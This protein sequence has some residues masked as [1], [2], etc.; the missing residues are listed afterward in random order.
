V[1]VTPHIGFNSYEAVERINRTTVEN[2]MGFAAGA[3]R[4]VVEAKAR[5]AM[6]RRIAM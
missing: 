3:P 5:R 2:I 1:I 6:P 4:N